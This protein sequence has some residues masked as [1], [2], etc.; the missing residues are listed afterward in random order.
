MADHSEY[1]TLTRYIPV[2][3]FIDMIK[4]DIKKLIHT[5]GHKNCGL[6]H[7][8]LCKEIKK[9]ISDNKKIVFQ[10]MDSPSKEEWSTKWD[11]QRNGFFNKLFEEEGFINMCVPKKKFTN[12]PSLNQLLSKH[13]DF[14][15]KKDER[16]SALRNK[17][18]YNACKQYN[19]WIDAQR[20]AFTNEYLNNVKVFKRPAVNK[21]FS[22]KEHPEGH[23][24]LKT[25][26][27]SKLNC[28]LYN[29]PPRSHPKGPVEKAPT[30]SLHSPAPPDLDQKSQGRGGKSIPGG[31]GGADKG[32]FDVKIPPRP[33]PPASDSLASS[34][35]KIKVDSTD[36]G[37]NPD[38]KA[39]G[40]DLPSKDQGAKG[41]PNEATYTK[42]QSPE[43][44][45]EPKSS[46]SSKDSPVTVVPDP[47]SSV[48]KDQGTSSYSTPITTSTTSGTTHS[49][50]N[51]SSPSAPDLSLVQTRSPA[52]AA[53]PSQHQIPATAQNS[54]ETTPPDSAGKSTDQGASRTSPL[55]PGLSPS[56]AVNSNS[57]ASETSS[58][59]TSITTSSTMTLTPG[60]SLS[61]D[62]HL[63][64]PSTQPIVTNSVATTLTQ[65]TTSVSGPPTVTVSTMNTN[66]ITSIIEI[67]ST[68]GG[69]GEPNALSKTITNSQDL[70]IASPKN[71]DDAL[72]TISGVQFPDA[73]SSATSANLNNILL[74]VPSSDSPTGLHSG[75][76]PGGPAPVHPAS[77]VVTK[78]DS[79]Q[80]M[81]SPKDAPQQS[82]DSTQV[83]STPLPTG[84]QPS[85]KS[86]ITPTKFP[87]L[88]SIIPTIVIILA[89][90][91]LLFQLYKYTPFGFL[92]G[93]KR[94]RKK[95]D[96]R[97]I[98][99]IPE[100]SAY[101]SPNITVHEWEDHNLGGKTVENDAYIKLFKINRYKQEM[102]KSKKKNKTTLI[103]VHME[104]LKEYKSDEWELHKGDFL[105]ICLRGFINEENEIYQNFSN[106]E[107]IVNNIKNEKTIEDI[108]KQEILWNNW[109]ENHRNILE[110]WKE[111]E[112]FHILKNKWRNEQQKY[113]EKNDKLQE[114]ILNEQETHSI[115]S[116][117]DIWKQWISKQATLI[118]TFNKEDWFKL[119]VYVQDKEKDNYPINEYNNISVTSKT[120]LKN[121]KMNHEHCKSKNI[122]QKLMVQIHMMVLEECIKEDI[123]KHKELC[124]D[125]FIE[126]IHNQN[127]Y[128]EKRNIPQ[129]DIH[130]F[131][132]PQYEE[133][134]ISR[135]K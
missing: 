126:D 47:F 14:C 88:T 25:Y 125:N 69:S 60:S 127:N 1:T 32:K 18:E 31:D 15:K 119:M 77:H 22:T 80:I 100:K 98:F 81:T 122:I 86:I 103:E 42:A 37:Q 55:D 67:T 11:R 38:L 35:T 59:T 91:T 70:N 17:S 53:V 104:V 58:T 56:Q 2:G 72:P 49:N 74:P 44:L 123:I 118:D 92:L 64:T 65:T 54:K 108:Q 40:T 124:I 96:L 5:Y 33:E 84:T 134:H 95:Q 68:K 73:P 121:E 57:S 130:D 24:P 129:C 116:Q 97:R 133:I 43:Q 3:F 113:K 99:E 13:I 79:N 48:I 66:P 90:I 111:K 50:Q 102:Q 20:T 63:S 109:I 36:N 27:N 105:E 128:D 4:G 107:L 85:D 114:N 12:N 82:K 7:E 21:Y 93:R 23:D 41:K 51:L 39:K 110:Q 112:W 115:V 30:I 106:S 132:V 10:H 19:M 131:D 75:V 46:I 87:P 6:M 101:K 45:S 62:P 34:E 52:V 83:S 16:L 78:P 28:N 135:N 76:S 29:P 117:K 89:T 9:I 8:E 71:Q 26:L 94:K 61:Q 120:G